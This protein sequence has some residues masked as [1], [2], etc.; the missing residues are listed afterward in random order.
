MAEPMHG[1]LDM[2]ILAVLTESPSH[3]YGVLE[4]I[5]Q[6]SAGQFDLPEGTVYPALYRLEGSGLLKS[7]WEQ[8]TGRRRRVYRLTAKG[9]TA[10]AAKHQDWKR[11]VGAVA[12]VVG[13]PA[14]QIEA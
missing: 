13:R 1:H 7:R 6:R 10:L 5:K 2:L 8:A 14:W 9:R 12:S 4:A 11:F 3:G